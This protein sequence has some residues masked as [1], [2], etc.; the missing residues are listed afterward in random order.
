MS[1]R[2]N[3]WFSWRLFSKQVIEGNLLVILVMWDT[4]ILCMLFPWPYVS[5]H[6]L[7]CWYHVLFWDSIPIFVTCYLV[8]HLMR[9]HISLLLHWDCLKSIHVVSMIILYLFSVFYWYNALLE[10]NAYILYITF[11]LCC[12]VLHLIHTITLIC[13]FTVTKSYKLN[14][15]V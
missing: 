13:C 9:S 1:P 12:M 3:L 8:L 6:S 10:S 4:S 7:P 5:F 15:E 2:V 11:G 14:I